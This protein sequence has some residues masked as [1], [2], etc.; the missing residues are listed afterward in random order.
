MKKFTSE[1]VSEGHPDKISDQISDA[2]LDAILLHDQNAK[3]ACE[4]MIKNSL[5]IVSGEITTN[6]WVDIESIV[7]EVIKD[8]GYNDSSL[9]LD[10]KNITVINIISRQSQEINESVFDTDQNCIGAGDQGIM[11]GY[12]C[13]ETEVYMP[14]AIYFSHKLLLDL[15]HLR[16][17]KKVSWLAPDAKCQVTVEYD[18]ESKLC[19]IDTILLSTQHLASVK[20]EEIE[21][22]MTKFIK[23]NKVL[24]PYLDN[25]TN[26]IINPSGS[27]VLGGPHADCGL[28]GRKIIVDSYGS[29]SKHG[30]GAFSGKDPS[31][32]DRSA[33]YM[34]RYIAKN[35][36]A[37][38]L[39]NKCEIQ[40]AYG[41]GLS[42]PLSISIDCF[43]SSKLSEEELITIV[44]KHFQ[45]KPSKIIESLK[46]KKFRY[47]NI[48]TYGHFGRNDY[49]LPWE[50]LDKVEVLQQYTNLLCLR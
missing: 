6:I 15:K 43:G 14:A 46:L 24:A 48:A 18:Q 11:F 8:I 28:T 30:G 4:T 1:S 40:L 2:I 5:V 13:N 20:K 3:V 12:A 21:L 31:K 41:I 23:M 38:K 7:K 42:D 36:V 39:A 44:T 50:V 45:L 29:Y 25:K 17:S 35:I 9:G 22:T 26:Y 16:K 10:Y 33:A 34:A 32:V 19:R 49:D 27:F 37:A 47:K